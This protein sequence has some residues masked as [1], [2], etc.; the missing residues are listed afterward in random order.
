MSLISMILAFAP[1]I[2]AK[3]REKRESDEVDALRSELERAWL[4]VKVRDAR[5][6]LLEGVLRSAQGSLADARRRIETLEGERGRDLERFSREAELR[7]YQEAAG[8]Q[9]AQQLAAY[10][11]LAQHR[12]A[13]AGLWEE[14]CNCV[15]TRA[16]V[17]GQIGEA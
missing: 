5:I 9:Q 13:Q 15:P 1:A 4:T 2:A 14:F 12:L 3:R 17:I 7:L 11:G 10:Q 6:E 16:S 8:M